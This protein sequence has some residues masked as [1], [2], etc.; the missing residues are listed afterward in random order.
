MVYRRLGFGLGVLATAVMCT[1]SSASAQERGW[2]GVEVVCS[3]CSYKGT[4]DFAVWSF[5]TAPEIR[6]VVDG[7]P[8]ARAGLEDGDTLMRINGLEITSEAGGRAFGAMS[9][10]AVVTLLVRRAGREISIAVTP[11]T[12]HDV[13]GEWH[14]LAVTQNGWDSLRVQFLTLS[15]EQSKLQTALRNAEVQLRRTEAMQVSVRQQEQAV[16][17]RVEVDS[18][19]RDLKQAQWKFKVQ[20]DSLAKR[21]LYVAPTPRPEVAVVVPQPE[22]RTL[23]V[24][25]NVVAGARFE[26]LDEESPLVSDL[27]GVEGGLLIVK[28]VEGTPAY[29]AGLRQGDVVFAINGEPVKS[30]ADLRRALRA[31][32][33]SQISY[34]RRGEKKS[35]TISSK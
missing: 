35:C 24:Y 34:V 1:V 5:E 14:Q 32:R 7:S 10:G 29:E 28:T 26:E 2:L 31:E 9:A 27:P 15:R 19:R 11:L 3:D 30:V 12:H 17:L 21:T 22:A 16:T 18:I 6:Q 4:D 13:Y 25:R 33:E 20:T 8:A 23:V